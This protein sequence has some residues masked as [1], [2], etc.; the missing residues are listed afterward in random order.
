M[1]PENLRNLRNISKLTQKQLADKLNVSF[2]TLSH[3]ENG[4]SEPNL[5]I[6]KSLKEILDVNYEELLE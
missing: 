2:K 3:W 5:T 4:Y 6:L 1:F